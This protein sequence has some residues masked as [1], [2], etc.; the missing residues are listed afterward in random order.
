MVSSVEDQAKLAGDGA[1]DGASTSLLGNAGVDMST[2]DT[3]KLKKSALSMDYSGFKETMGEDNVKALDTSLL[4]GMGFKEET[5]A[6]MVETPSLSKTDLKKMSLEA[7][8]PSLKE[9]DIDFS[10]L[11]GAALTAVLD[12]Q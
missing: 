12:S 7:A 3:D 4:V 5:A 2:I 6:E 1:F 11:S 9:K 10:S 8:V